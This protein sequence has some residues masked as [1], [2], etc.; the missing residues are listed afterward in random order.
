MQ[1]RKKEDGQ[2][3]VERENKLLA[4]TDSSTKKEEIEAKLEMCV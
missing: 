3:V 1:K 2:M 4:G